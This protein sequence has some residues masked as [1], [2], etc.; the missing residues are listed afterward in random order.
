M[1]MNQIF[2][3]QKKNYQ[4]WSPLF[5]RLAI[6]AGFFI[7]GWAKLLRGPEGFAKLLTFLNVPMPHFMAWLVTLIEI[8]GGLA[9]IAGLLVSFFAVPLAA[10]MLVAMF[11]I[12]IHY[13]FS[14]IKTIGMNDQGPLFGPPGYELNLLYIAG[15]LSLIS[16]G[17]GIF[18]LDKRIAN[19]A[20]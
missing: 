8:I 5:L 1:K 2:S 13:G 14:S 18:S 4:L 3:V 15:L 20:H 9:L 17:A 12:H 19:R 10:T 11:T 16:T 7:H 6:G